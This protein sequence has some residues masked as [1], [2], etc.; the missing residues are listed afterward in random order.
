MFCPRPQRERILLGCSR[1]SCEGQALFKAD[2]ARGPPGLPMNPQS[3][4]PHFPLAAGSCVH[5]RR[6]LRTAMLAFGL[7]FASLCGTT[8]QTNR[9]YIGF[10]YPAGGQRGT[11]FQIR[12]GGQALD[13]LSGVLVTGG[14]VTAKLTENYRR[15]NMEEM[16]V[17]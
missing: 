13:E 3:H 14:G 9:P 16:L 4:Q 11:T 7:L 10:V 2:A 12:L 6:S 15:L 8:A 1:K 17:L 5:A